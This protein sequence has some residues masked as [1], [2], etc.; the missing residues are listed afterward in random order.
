MTYQNDDPKAVVRHIQELLRTIQINNDKIVTVPID[1]IYG[2]ET[3]I[4]ISE[5]QK[6]YGLPAT[7]NVDRTT[8]D[9]LYEIASA[10][11]LNNSSPLPLYLLADGQSIFSG[12][13]SNVV[14]ITQILL[15]SLTVS[16]DDFEP[17]NI[18]GVFG[19]ETE[20]A[21]RRFQMRNNIPPNGFVDKTTWNALI[22]NYDK[23]IKNY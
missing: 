6:E 9:T 13:K 12:E 10:A 18:D 4:A 17:L 11:V 1:G 5:L 16:Y 19:E 23:H 15:N 21:V 22:R 3:A 7:G 8:Y 14:M 20:R 2:T